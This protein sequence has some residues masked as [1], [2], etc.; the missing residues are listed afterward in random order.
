MLNDDYDELEF[1]EF[2]DIVK[3][4]KEEKA[5]ENEDRKKKL[6]GSQRSNPQAG[7][8][9]KYKSNPKTR[10]CRTPILVDLRRKNPQVGAGPKG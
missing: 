4:G 7:G 3:K 8:Y 10:Y 1:L 6:V 2:D 5:T 9:V